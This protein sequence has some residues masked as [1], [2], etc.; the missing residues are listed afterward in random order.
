VSL[1]GVAV[2]AIVAAAAFHVAWRFGLVPRRRRGVTSV[3]RVS[4]LKRRRPGGS[5]PAL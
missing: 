2:A 5:P 4:E 1:Q 3:V